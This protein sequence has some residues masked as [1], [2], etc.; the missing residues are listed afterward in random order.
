[1]D[2]G[3]GETIRK[4]E[5]QK[6]D[7]PV[8]RLGRQINELFAG[9]ILKQQED[10]RRPKEENLATRKQMVELE[11]EKWEQNSRME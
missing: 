7:Q 3:G 1:M 8:E 6:N 5:Q 2:R 4:T 9:L 10:N 11:K